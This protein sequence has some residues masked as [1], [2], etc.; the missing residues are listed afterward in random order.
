MLNWGLT[1]TLCYLRHLE[2]LGEAA[3]MRQGGTEILGHFLPIRLVLFEKRMPSGWRVGIKY[4][5]H[6]SRLLLLDQL[7]DC[8]RETKQG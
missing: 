7:N 8:I 6:V 5:R 1:E 3:Q 4:H 2:R